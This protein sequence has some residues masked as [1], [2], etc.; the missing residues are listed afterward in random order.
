MTDRWQ[1][2]FAEHRQALDRYV[3]T[4]EA[5]G[6]ERWNLEREPGKWPPSAITRHLIVYY[7]AAA[8]VL[9]GE[10]EM[11]YR[12]GPIWRTAL[13]WILIPHILYHRAFPLRVVAPREVRPPEGDP[14]PRLE[15]VRLLRD[16]VDR[17][18]AEVRDAAKHRDRRFGHPYFGRISPLR[19]LR[20]SSAHMDHHRRQVEA[21]P[22]PD[23]PSRE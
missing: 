7:D 10:L 22:R 9:R 15:S 5:L 16:A 1:A 4:I 19:L 11:R 2:A 13:R 8:K 6:D 17:A 21:T 12:V 14:L 23:L 3:A 18:E 20:L